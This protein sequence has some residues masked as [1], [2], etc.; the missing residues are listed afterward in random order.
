MQYEATH[1]AGHDPVGWHGTTILCVRRG[2]QVAMAGDGQVTMGQTVVKG[3]A[4]KVRRIGAGNA[5]LAGFAG[6]TADAF[7]LLERLEAKLERYPGQ[8]E[9]A[10]VELA[11][12]WRTDRYLRRLEAMMA[13]ADADRSFTLTG[14]GDVL[15]P[16]DGVIAIGSGGNYALA[17]ARALMEASDLTAEEIARR[18]M[19]IAG[20]ICVYTNHSV[21]V[22]TIA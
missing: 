11:K 21:I 5:V 19:K 9:R 18:A 14:N 7:T 16:E 8:L 17:A 4:R 3:N 13:V 2:G 10:C 12:D 22:E 1:S 6:A 20:D 15:E